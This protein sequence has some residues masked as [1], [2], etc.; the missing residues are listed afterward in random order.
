MDEK[1]SSRLIGKMATIALFAKRYN[2]VYTQL[3]DPMSTLSHVIKLIN[4]RNMYME[5]KM[6]CVEILFPSA[7]K[8]KPLVVLLTD[9][10]I[11]DI[12]KIDERILI[13][14]RSD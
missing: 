6:K 12:K 7:Y 4:Q 1:R 11:E 10:Q 3:D 5:D 8:I 14:E 9:E 13:E 2:V